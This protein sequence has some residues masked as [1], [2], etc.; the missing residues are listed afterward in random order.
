MQA[1]IGDKT[2]ADGPE[3]SVDRKSTRIGRFDAFC[4]DWGVPCLA[5]LPRFGRNTQF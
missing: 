4:P 2:A 1:R 3:L 5:S